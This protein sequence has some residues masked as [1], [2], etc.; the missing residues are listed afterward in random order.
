M[1]VTPRPGGLAGHLEATADDPALPVAAAGLSTAAHVVRWVGGLRV[2]EEAP[3][4]AIRAAF[5]ALAPTLPD[6]R[7]PGAAFRV[8]CRRAGTHPFTSEDVERTAGAGVRAAV[9]CPVRLKG[10]AVALRCDVRDRE[11]RLG[12]EVAVPPRPAPPCP[13]ATSLKPQLAAGLLAL[14]RPFG[15]PAPRA[16]LDPFVGGATILREAAR[17]WPEARLAGSDLHPGRA[18]GARA[19]LAGDAGRTEVRAGDARALASLWAG[20]AFDLVATN[21]PFGER[22]GRGVDLEALYRS[23]LAGAAAVTAPDA[24]LVVLARRRG[25]FNRALRAEGSWDTVHVRIVE[26]GGLYAGAFVLAKR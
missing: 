13:A 24:R 10:P 15:G 11:A 3:L 20:G 12:V 5:T 18:E 22:L 14:A 1:V 4:D 25:H 2:P 21:P 7:A 26:L 19:N 16:V 17:R 8:R 23:L 9:A 6:L